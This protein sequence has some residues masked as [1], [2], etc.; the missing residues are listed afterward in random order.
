[1]GILL[2]GFSSVYLYVLASSVA[3]EETTD[4]RGAVSAEYI[5]PRFPDASVLGDS[6]FEDFE[7]TAYCI[8]GTTF[9]G[10]VVQ[11][12]IVAADP[13]ILPIGSVIE[14]RAGKYSG[15]YTV[16]DTGAVIKGRIIDIYMPEYEEAIEFGRQQVQLRVLR[17]GWHPEESTDFNL[18]VAG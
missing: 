5:G 9:S 14:V 2:A 7:A 17:H 4:H 16:M 12:G 13:S 11:R 1:M 10:V 15:I 8:Y 6:E 3:W 18:S